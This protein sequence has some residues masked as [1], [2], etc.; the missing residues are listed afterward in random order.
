MKTQIEGYENFPGEHCG[1]SAMRGLLN[2][3]CGLRLPEPAVFGL[4]SALDCM[5]IASEESDPPR[6]V[7]GRALSLEVD[8]AANLQIDY[9]EQTV[10]DDDEAWRLVR[11]EVAA[12]RPTMLSGD[13]FYLDYRD[14]TVHFP[15]HRFVLLG[16][17]EEAGTAQIADRI[18]VES[19][20]CSLGSIRESRNPPSQLMSTQNLW[21]KFHGR[22]V[23][24]SVVDATRLAIQRECERMLAPTVEPGGLPMQSGLPA[25]R[26]MA[27]EIGSWGERENAAWIAS[28]NARAIEK[29]GNG[30]GNF[31]RLYAGFLAWAHDLD[32]SLVKPEAAGVATQAADEWTSLADTLFA[33][34]ADEADPHGWQT[35]SSQA[36]SIAAT[37]TRL[38]EL[39]SA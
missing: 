17:D 29:F 9:R 15:G 22:E 7:F 30:G 20:T 23:G 24:R 34:S 35:A 31:R 11:D 27:E 13:I 12:G 10:A 36:G 37:E 38:F 28:Y 33:L 5:Y 18:R 3:Y 6:M 32:S 39:L 26:R 25:L 8:L 2:H 1:S 14:Y 4:G 16:F 19:E 21:G